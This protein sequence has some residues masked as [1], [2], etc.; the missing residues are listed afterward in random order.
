MLLDLALRERRVVVKRI[1]ICDDEPAIG[2]FVQA[3]AQ[4]LGYEV[5]LTDGVGFASAYEAFLPNVV[6]L[7]MVMPGIDGHEV[8]LW[9]AQRSYTERLIIMT[10]YNPV[11]AMHAKMLAEYR[12][13]GPVST[14][15]KP[16][17]QSI[18]RAALSSD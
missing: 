7:D 12:G 2:R 14:L 4:Q 11:Y 1:L 18:L 6:L 15:Q 16:L 8:I 13:L 17:S 5:R 9:L 3:I 10:G